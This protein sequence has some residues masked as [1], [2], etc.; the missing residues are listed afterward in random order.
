MLIAFEG[1][2]GSGK[3]TQ[4]RLLAARLG[5]VLTFEPGGTSLGAELRA[6]LLDGGDVDPRAEALA[7][8][9]DRAQH[10]AEVI[11]PALDRGVH[12]VTDRYLYSSLAY[13]GFGRN[14]GVDAVRSLS[15]FA[16]A[17]EADLVIL[18]TISPTM[19]R[20]RLQGKLDRIESDG[21]EFHERVE[22]G[23]LE[24]AARDR[25]RWVIITGTG[26][27]EAIADLVWA[28]VNARL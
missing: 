20:D 26:S 19:R 12:V 17:P 9:A 7:M 13:Q 22:K 27:V 16:G 8:A 14:L 15:N 23:F 18:L 24:L 3:S 5:A 25:K 6:S 4:A 28:E 11:Q 21:D 1:G 2:E 10:V